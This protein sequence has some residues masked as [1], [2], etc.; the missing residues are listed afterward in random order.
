MSS[1]ESVRYNAGG[2]G[3]HTWSKALGWGKNRSVRVNQGVHQGEP[4]RTGYGVAG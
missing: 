2:Q 1:V 3:N 4:L